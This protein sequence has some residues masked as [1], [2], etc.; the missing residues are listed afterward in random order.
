MEEYE[1]LILMSKDLMLLAFVITFTLSL[2]YLLLVFF[3]LYCMLRVFTN[4]H[5]ELCVCDAFL[6]A[7]YSYPFLFYKLSIS[8]LTL[9][10]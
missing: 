1:N 8:I 10:E 7:L 5:E 4:L 2:Y 6:F 9:I 3:V